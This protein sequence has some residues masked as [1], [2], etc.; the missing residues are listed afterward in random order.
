MSDLMKKVYYTPSNPG[1]L[2]GKN[3]LKRGVLND[4]GVRLTDKQISEWLAAEDAYTLHKTGTPKI[5]EK[6]GI[7]LWYE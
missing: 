4:S 6:Q 5:Q 7:C 2:G 3:R 1:S